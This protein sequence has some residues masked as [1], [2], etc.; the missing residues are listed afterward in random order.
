MKTESNRNVSSAFTLIEL[1]VVIAIIA[2]LAGMLLPALSRAKQAG[3]SA[4]CI[5]NLR[6]FIL[7]THLYINDHSVYPIL[8][9]P[10]F[11][12]PNSPTTK[13]W[14]DY[15]APYT[16]NRLTNDLYRC[17]DYPGHTRI[18]GIVF[19]SP[20]N[21]DMGSYGYNALGASDGIGNGF[22]LGGRFGRT[23]EHFIAIRD[24]QVRV[25]SQMVA[26]GDSVL[27]A[28]TWQ[29]VKKPS[30]QV[31]LAW[32]EIQWKELFRNADTAADFRAMETRHRGRFNTAF[33]DGHVEAIRLRVLFGKTQATLRLWNNDHDPHLNDMH[34]RLRALIRP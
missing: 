31:G 33:A 8:A 18:R 15:I 2:I 23:D 1:L 20:E 9:D 5:S 13:I 12:T 14:Y 30:G 4:G 32:T 7:A 21:N 10:G 11:G 25:P 24:S 3:K 22:G 26:F 6:Q 27:N 19:D 28:V 29:R 17:L 16:A 34:P